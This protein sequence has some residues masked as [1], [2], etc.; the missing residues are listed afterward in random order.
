MILFAVLWN[1]LTPTVR[2]YV[3]DIL[4]YLTCKYVGPIYKLRLGGDDRIFISSQELV[5]EICSRKEFV[6]IPIGAIRQLQNVTPDGLFTAP[7]GQESWEV[8]HRTLIPAF[9]PI[10]VQ[11]MLPGMSVK[12]RSMV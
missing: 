8:A 10:P 5:N 3:T 9:G 7:H 6:K 1:W 11:E 12:S 4:T 2:P